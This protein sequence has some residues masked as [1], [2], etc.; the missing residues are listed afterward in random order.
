MT[1]PIL[2]DTGSHYI[3]LVGKAYEVYRNQGCAAVKC[4]TIGSSLGFARA[5]AEADRR[6]A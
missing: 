2:Y 4:A 6:S 1:T 5:K 3:I